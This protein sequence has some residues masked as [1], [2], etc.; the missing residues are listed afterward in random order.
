ME[1]TF[2]P[3]HV[4]DKFHKPDIMFSSSELQEAGGCKTVS[5]IPAVVQVR[6]LG[7]PK[8]SYCN[9]SC[10]AFAF[11]HPNTHSSRELKKLGLA[12]EH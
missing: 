12:S 1:K 7:N 8:A 10:M 11:P 6:G 9:R 4:Q 5:R 3:G 2:T